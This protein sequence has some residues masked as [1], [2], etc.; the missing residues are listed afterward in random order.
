MGREVLVVNQNF[1]PLNVTTVRRA[2]S[3]VLMR[4]A[5]VVEENGEFIHSFQRTF[6]APSVIRMCYFVRRPL[7]ELKLTRKSVFA[8]DG[9]TCQYC[10]RLD[11]ALTIDHIV[12]KSAGGSSD[13]DNVVTCCIR[14]NNL[15]GNR[16][17]RMAGMRQKRRPRRPRFTPYISLSSYLAARRASMWP[18][19]LEPWMSYDL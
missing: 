15:K 13:W 7:P 8:R 1:E 10:G 4:K 9:Y 18:E 17:P 5:E 3:V 12:P 16:T 14:C 11:V 19:Y 6:R 2:M